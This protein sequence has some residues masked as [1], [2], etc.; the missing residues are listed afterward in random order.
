VLE[1]T[2]HLHEAGAADLKTGSQRGVA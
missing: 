1:E 2:S